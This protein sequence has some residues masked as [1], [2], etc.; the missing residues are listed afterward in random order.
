MSVY[1]YCSIRGKVFPL[2][3]I[4]IHTVSCFFLCR[5]AI[6]GQ[7]PYKSIRPRYNF[8]DNLEFSAFNGYLCE[9]TVF[10]LDKINSNLQISFISKNEGTIALK[11]GKKNCLY[12]YVYY[13]DIKCYT[14]FVCCLTWTYNYIIILTYRD[15]YH[16]KILGRGWFRFRKKMT[17]IYK[18]KYA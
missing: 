2:Y 11:S 10:S 14:T 4:Y 17:I 18:S 1:V 3:Y 5:R 7:G 16:I 6:L 8:D 15:Y 12:I 9:I 13:K